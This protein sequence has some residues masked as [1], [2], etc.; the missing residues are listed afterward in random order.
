MPPYRYRS[1]LPSLKNGNGSLPK[2][3]TCSWPTT[4]MLTNL[5]LHPR[6]LLTLALSM[7]LL[8]AVVAMWTRYSAFY[9][10]RWHP[11][12]TRSGE[13]DDKFIGNKMT[14]SGD[15]MVCWEYLKYYC[16]RLDC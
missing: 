4:S 2:L 14:K 3:F 7:L 1:V 16:P 11:T 12:D 9:N 5:L 8:L 15:D 6:L 10:V 13:M